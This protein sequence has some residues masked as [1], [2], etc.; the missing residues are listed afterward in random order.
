MDLQY[1]KLDGRLCYKLNTWLKKNGLL[2]F[3]AELKKKTVGRSNYIT[4][5]VDVSSW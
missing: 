2:T 3:N 5:T 1:G 4:N